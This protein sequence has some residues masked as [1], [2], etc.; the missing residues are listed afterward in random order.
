ME[1]NYSNYFP[2]FHMLYVAISRMS[3]SDEMSPFDACQLETRHWIIT[4]EEGR[5]DRVDGPGVVGRNIVV[6][7]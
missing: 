4:D 5:E 1:N 3:M 7:I 2:E 6:Y